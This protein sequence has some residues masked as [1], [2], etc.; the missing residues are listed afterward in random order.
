MEP[1]GG[2]DAGATIAHVAEMGIC[3]N[4]SRARWNLRGA[5]LTA[6]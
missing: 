6:P 1:R 3:G 4:R 5:R 2:F